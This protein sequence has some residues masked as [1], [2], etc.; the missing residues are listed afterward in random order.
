MDIEKILA[1]LRQEH[2]LI[3]EAIISLERMAIGRGKR[4]G[5]PPKWMVAASQK[6]TLPK[7]RGRPPGS[8]NAPKKNRRVRAVAQFLNAREA[9]EIRRKRPDF[10]ALHTDEPDDLPDSGQHR[11]SDDRG[12]SS[13]TA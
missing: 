8:K 2:A 4:R 1:G 7:R 10:L 3:T 11:L 13:M 12:K 6:V 5:R 9:G